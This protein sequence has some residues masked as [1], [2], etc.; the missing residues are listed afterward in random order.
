MNLDKVTN[1]S[2]SPEYTFNQTQRIILQ[3][4]F[5]I[6]NAIRLLELPMFLSTTFSKMRKHRIPLGF[7]LFALVFDEFLCTKMKVI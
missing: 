2:R 6:N 5:N 3:K 7:L 1:C 4:N